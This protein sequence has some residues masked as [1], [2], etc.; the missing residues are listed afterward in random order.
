MSAL[1][2]ELSIGDQVV[3]TSAP[4]RRGRVVEKR[5]GEHVKVQWADG[6]EAW[7]DTCQLRKIEDRFSWVSREEFLADLAILKFDYKFSDVVFSM[8]ASRTQFLPYQFK[9]VLQFIQQ[10]PHGLLIADE[11]G[12]GK[13]IE[14]ALITRELIARGS[15]SRILVVCPANL[16]EKW[17]SELR[18][19][20]GMEFRN[21]KAGDFEEF[22][23]RSEREGYWPPFRGIVSLQGL[24]G[25]DFE[26]TIVNTG[27]QFDLVIVDEAHHMR[28][29]ATQSFALGEALAEQADHVLLLSATPVQTGEG[30][31]LS[32][33]R[34]LELGEFEDVSPN[35][36]QSRLEPNRYL[37]AATRLLSNPNPDLAAVA[38]EMKR[39]LN[40]YHGDTFRE[41][42]VFMNWI[43]RIED[44]DSLTPESIVRLRRDI[45]NVHTLAPYYT[46]TRKVE[47]QE[48][49][50]RKANTLSVELTEAERE[51]YEAWVAFIRAEAV[52]RGIH[53]A[54]YVVLPE[55]QAASSIHAVRE[56]VEGRIE[57]ALR[58]QWIDKDEDY[59]GSAFIEEPQP[60]DTNQIAT[61]I[62]AAAARLREAATGL[63]DVDSK[64][65]KF[66]EMLRDLLDEKP[67]RK[68]ICFTE[69]R[70]SLHRLS[71][72]LSRESIP[73]IA[74]SGEVNPRERAKR[75]DKFRRDSDIRVLVST[76]VGSEGL[77][78]QFCDAVIN[79]DLPWNP[80][81]VEQRIGRIDR[82]GQE[83]DQVIVSSLFVEDTIDT[84]VLGRLYDRI[85][86]FEQA[87]GQ[88]EP[89]LGP[90]I[91]SLQRDVLAREMTPEEQEQRAHAA[92]LRIEQNR[93]DLEELDKRQAELMGQGDLL[94][95]EAE[96]A[97]ET[98]RYISADE[99][100]AIVERWLA[101]GG[102]KQ[103][104]LKP[105]RRQKV[106]DLHI[107]GTKLDEVYLWMQANRSLPTADKDDRPP[108]LQRIQVERNAWITFD[109]TTA[110]ENPRLPF[111]H[112]SHEIVQ[113][114]ISRLSEAGMNLWK[115][116]V[117]R[118]R[119][120]DD[121]RED[122]SAADGVL[123]TIWRITVHGLDEQ[124]TMLPIA[125]GA[126]TGEILENCSERLLGALSA[127]EGVNATSGIDEDTV[128][129][130]YDYSFE[131][132]ARRRRE[133]EDLTRDQQESRVAVQTAT[134]KRSYNARIRRSA[135]LARNAT[136]DRIRRMHN[137]RVH[138]L[139]AELEDRL[140]K[141]TS[142]P[143]P[144]A[145]FDIIAM[146]V[147][148]PETP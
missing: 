95:R 94:R 30:D 147:F 76:E 23:R 77:D 100:Y 125:M 58:M 118:F 6:A 79:F 104:Q 101:V 39:A 22:K 110:R 17:R 134:L 102:S 43:R 138:N 49:A 141:L 20:F 28:N 135:K 25:A 85:G 91:T 11:V 113:T 83:E 66:V 37:N 93:Q 103:D 73:S 21:L 12:L 2:T 64:F 97:R 116:R 61:P 44:I 92:T 130:G 89:I 126:A 87:I 62:E 80:M 114:A 142:A 46:R 8:G 106:L 82:F 36:L 41:D 26:E 67:D 145:E 69:W 1:S 120:P 148:A 10:N 90:A 112:S 99:V 60:L 16:R 55:R 121:L 139:K 45:Q 117:G 38:T 54:F 59:E 75:I 96:N 70:G 34:I 131:E 140:A 81:R 42:A 5:D 7:V 13:T 84:R 146:A 107:S 127:S 88:L 9:P 57:R 18:E 72:Y 137:G 47:V 14:A 19:R 136:D 48:I 65:E 71:E 129:L 74:I 133:I 108:L 24:R 52:L 27:I 86:V 51:F 105:T 115:A 128:M 111:L 98:G 3:L 4:H 32:L 122:A 63:P 35:E 78:F 56:S 132:A 50:Q 29:P 123:L 144:T 124:T 31:L 68:V 15:I 109:D 33:L 53:P 119:L 40:T 143:E